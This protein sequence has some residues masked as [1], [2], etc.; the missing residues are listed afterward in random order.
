MPVF[1]TEFP[2]HIDVKKF[3]EHKD[4]VNCVAFSTDFEILVTGELIFFM[5]SR[6]TFPPVLFFYLE[7]LVDVPMDIQ[8]VSV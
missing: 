8:C 1:N 7:P 2:C 5:E 6:S 4:E 3:A